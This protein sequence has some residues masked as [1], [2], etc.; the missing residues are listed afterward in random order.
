MN[1]FSLIALIAVCFYCCSEKTIESDIVKINRLHD[2]AHKILIKPTPTNIDSVL[3]YAKNAELIIKHGRNIPDTLKIENLFKKGLYYRKSNKMDSASYYFHRGID[4]IKSPNN[5]ERNIL[6]FRNTWE[7]DES[8][9]KFTSAVSTAQ[10][11]INISDKEN[12]AGDLV[13]AYNLLEKI[14]LE[15]EN[16]DKSKYYNEL[17]MKAAL[18]SENYDMYI[19]TALSK[20]KLLKRSNKEIEASKFLDSIIHIASTNIEVQRQLIRDV[21]IFSC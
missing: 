16:E 13:Y 1:K 21:G 18:R 17:T 8:L 15:L 11:F 14:Y 6:Y 3:I 4:L 12:Y 5:R 19:I 7:T 10:K 2:K 20:A 9:G